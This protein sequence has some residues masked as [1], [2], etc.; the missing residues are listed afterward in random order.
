M[1]ACKRLHSAKLLW[2]AETA[3]IEKM[4]E[5]LNPQLNLSRLRWLDITVPEAEGRETAWLA[6]FLAQCPH[7]RLFSATIERLCWL[8]PLVHIKH[9]N[10]VFTTADAQREN[11]F[12]ALSKAQG[13]QTLRLA[14]CTPTHVAAAEVPRLNLSEVTGLQSLAIDGFIP[15]D[16]RL[17]QGCE[18]HLVHA[19]PSRREWLQS[20]S[21][22]YQLAP[23]LKS[24]RLTMK[25]PVP[26]LPLV[27]GVQRNLH[28]VFFGVKSFGSAENPGSLQHLAFVHFDH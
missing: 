2:V 27:F 1:W 25:A 5:A 23:H 18:L 6:W 22:P 4:A 15:A 8:P 16:L 12:A 3:A 10:L 21:A 11:I 28:T 24:L 14:S 19:D 26:G 20:M 13:L 17:P 9:L 7:L